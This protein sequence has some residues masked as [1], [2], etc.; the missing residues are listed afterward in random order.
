ME[1]KTPETPQD[2]KE[3]AKGRISGRQKVLDKY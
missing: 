2:F 3:N 1:K